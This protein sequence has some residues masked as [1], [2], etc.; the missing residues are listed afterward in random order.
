MQQIGPNAHRA[1]VRGRGTQQVS[2]Q[3]SA[4]ADETATQANVVSAASEQV[5]KNVQTVATGADEMG[6]S[7]KEIAKNT[8]RR[9]PGGHHGG[10][11]GGNHQRRPSASW[12]RAA[13]RSAR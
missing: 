3:M 7:I 5:S 1:G 9:H 13:P 12:A 6:A 2:Q 10:Q 11:V 4:S 8:G